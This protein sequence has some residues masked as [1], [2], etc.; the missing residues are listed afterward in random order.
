MFKKIF[1]EFLNSDEVKKFEAENSVTPKRQRALAFGAVLMFSNREPLRT[2]KMMHANHPAQIES[3]RVGFG[4][5]WGIYDGQEALDVLDYLSKAAGHAIFAGE[6]YNRFILPLKGDKRFGVRNL[7]ITPNQIQD[8]RGL[9]RSYERSNGDLVTLCER[10]NRGLNAYDQVWYDLQ[11]IGKD[12]NF[13]SE[14]LLSIGN[15]AAW[16]LGRVVYIARTSAAL[17][18]V[19]EEQTWPYI[20]KAADIA[21][22]VYK[23]WRQYLAAYCLG[24]ALGFGSYKN[25]DLEVRYLLKDPNSPYND[26]SFKN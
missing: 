26:S 3:L 8:L 18:Y 5:W 22:E 13:S 19:E 11:R 10:I 15:F 17:G 12:H 16:D 7:N 4:E 23:D 6:A 25:I 20:E 14:E 24:R 1:Q 9:E 2:F 21:G